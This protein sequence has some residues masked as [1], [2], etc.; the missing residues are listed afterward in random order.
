ME[1]VAGSA[2]DSWRIVPATM[3]KQGA[4]D[5]PIADRPIA[6]LNVS[7]QGGHGGSA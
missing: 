6:D 7:V 5:G 3:R 2:R 4:D 1:T